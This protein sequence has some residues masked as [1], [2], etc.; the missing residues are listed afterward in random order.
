MGR[1]VGNSDS[2]QSQTWEETTTWLK[3]K[4]HI[5]VRVVRV[6]RV[7]SFNRVARMCLSWLS[8]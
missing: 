7:A 4:S 5:Y 8:S 3:H 6:V 1:N 2:E